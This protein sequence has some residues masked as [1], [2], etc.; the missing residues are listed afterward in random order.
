MVSV[1]Y[2]LWYMHHSPLE[3]AAEGYS[4]MILEDEPFPLTVLWSMSF[5]VRQRRRKVRGIYLGF[6]FHSCCCFDKQITPP[7]RPALYRSRGARVLL[8]ARISL[9]ALFRSVPCNLEPRS[10]SRCR[11]NRH[12]NNCFHGTKNKMVPCAEVSSTC[13]LLALFRLPSRP[14]NTNKHDL[15]ALAWNPFPGSLLPAPL[16]SSFV[17]R[18]V[19]NVQTV[20]VPLRPLRFHG[21]SILARTLVMIHHL[22]IPGNQRLLCVFLDDTAV[23]KPNLVQS[24]SPHPAHPQIRYADT[25]AFALLCCCSH[26]NPTATSYSRL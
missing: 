3:E 26:T 25:C 12:R 8:G 10:K 13:K 21:E 22:F 9:L 17:L 20:C 11:P 1:S 5:Y 2:N 15:H 18:F 7:K 6:V 19:Q 14:S 4:V 24:R 23:V 16:L